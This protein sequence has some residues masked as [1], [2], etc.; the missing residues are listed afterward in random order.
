MLVW[1]LIF[2]TITHYF[3]LY[4]LCSGSS[5]RSKPEVAVHPKPKETAGNTEDNDI[6]KE[7]DSSEFIKVH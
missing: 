6:M 7:L 5:S 1:I 4:L 2:Y 3:V